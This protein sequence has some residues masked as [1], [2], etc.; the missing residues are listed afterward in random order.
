VIKLSPMLLMVAF[1]A[2]TGYSMHSNAVDPDA[3]PSNLAKEVDGIVQE[4]RA[5]GNALATAPAGSLRDPFQIVT[6]PAGEA[7]GGVSKDEAPVEPE[8]DVLADIVKKMRLDGTFVQGSEQMA[9]I[10]GRVY[11]K[12]Q[13]I[14][15]SGD[16]DKSVPKLILVGVL[17]SKAIVHADSRNFVLTYSD[18]LGSSLERGKS[19][20]ESP[21][22]AMAEIDAGGQIAMF[23]K[24]LNSPLGALGK[25]MIGNGGKPGG[26][27]GATSRSRRPRT[28]P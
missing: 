22:D 21:Q 19:A 3:G 9:I 25:S 12:G 6:K 4:M 5:V 20:A 26:R 16:Q 15:V 23:Q 27:R 8:T 10:D 28:N 17:P 11:T 13:R 2:Y 14:G 7:A 18:Q 24:L 1:L